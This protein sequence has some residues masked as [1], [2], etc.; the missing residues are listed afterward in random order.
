MSFDSEAYLNE[1]A[2]AVDPDEYARMEDPSALFKAEREVKKLEAEQRERE[3]AEGPTP[4]LPVGPSEDV[5][6][7]IK[8]KL[9]PSMAKQR[10]QREYYQPTQLLDALPGLTESL[11]AT[12][13]LVAE[14]RPIQY[15][16][17]LKL[18]AGQFWAEVNLF[19]GKNAFRAVMTTKT[20]SHPKLAELG[21]DAIQ[22]YFDSLMQQDP[23]AWQKQSV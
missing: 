19:Y 6:T 22:L 17:Q 16:R 3:S 23:L 9:L 11:A 15:G 7:R 18:T 8:Q 20:G 10:P 4:V 14:H 12:G 2:E 1:G 5:L 21:R 13:I